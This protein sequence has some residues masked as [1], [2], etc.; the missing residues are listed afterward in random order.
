MPFSIRRSMAITFRSL[1]FYLS[2][3]LWTAF[4]AVVML[5]FFLLPDSAKIWGCRTWAVASTG[6]LGKICRIR[7]VVRG[8]ENIPS[9][10]CVIVAN[11]QSA[12]ETL[13]LWRFFPRI[14][15]VLKEELLKIPVLGWYLPFSWPIAINRQSG[16][17][18]LGEILEEGNRRLKAGYPVL[19]F[20][21]GTRQEC[22]SLGSFHQTGVALAQ[23]A[24]VPLLPLALN[25]GCFWPR[26]D[27]RK[28]PGTVHL[29]FGNPR[30]PE[31]RSAEI[32]REIHAWIRSVLVT[33]P[34]RQS[35]AS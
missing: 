30:N 12:M 35:G 19:I 33:L 8:E 10:P 31:G 14:S 20:P 7:L 26:N 22:G 21:E 29:H 23:K 34:R 11:H 13:L 25:T 2:F 27:W 4:W 1:L 17:R 3:A 6:L 9:G 18:A 5:P 15:F 32:N 24:G 16:K 28:Y